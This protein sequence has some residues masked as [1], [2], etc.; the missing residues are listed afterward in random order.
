[1]LP[2]SITQ[3]TLNATAPT[4]QGNWNFSSEK[5]YSTVVL[6]EVVKAAG[7]MLV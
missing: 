7:Q 2:L 4:L 3:L 5:E 6:Q 1:M